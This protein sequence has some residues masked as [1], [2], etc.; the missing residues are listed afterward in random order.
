MKRLREISPDLGC[1]YDGDHEHFVITHKRA[2]GQPVPIMLIEGEGGGF[3]HPDERDLRKIKEGDTHRVPIKDKL[4]AVAK[5]MAEDRAKKRADAKDEIR[6]RTKDDKIQLQ[7][8]IGRLAN[9]SKG[10]SQFRR[11]DIKPRGKTI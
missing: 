6:N 1:K 9:V 7:K 8:A 2:V 11:V 5:Y 10:N 4:K 3:R